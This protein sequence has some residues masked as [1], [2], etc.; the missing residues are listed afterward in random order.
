MTVSNLVI[1]HPTTFPE[2][3][4]A[5]VHSPGERISGSRNEVWLCPAY[6]G[7]TTLLMYVKPFLGIRQIVAE[8]V[9]A[10]V[11]LCLGLPCPPPFLVSVAPHHVGG[12]RGGQARLTFG[13]QHVGPA[14]RA[15]PVRSLSVMLEM[16]KK[17]RHA[18]GTCL[19]DEWI[20]NA[21]RGPGDILFDAS[22]AVWL[23]DH[24]AAF[25]P[26][27]RPDEAVTNWLANELAQ[28]LNR[29]QRADFLARLAAKLR[30]VADSRLGRMPPELQAAERGPEAYR[31]VI[32]FLEA[33]LNHLGD[34]LSKRMLPEQLTLSNLPQSNDD[35][36]RAADL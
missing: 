6:S 18:E 36:Q 5:S 1:L 8:L 19:L 12:P 35:A 22:K 4:A 31:A 23:V 10:Q 34:L 28:G 30:P 29:T 15:F 9:G 17:T 3:R 14:S 32:E 2:I 13:A 26:N 21:V 24:E 7:S 16:L 20:A 11:G 33:R 25:D 27:V